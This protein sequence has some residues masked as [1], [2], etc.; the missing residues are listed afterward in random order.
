MCTAAAPNADR[1]QLL[2]AIMQEGLPHQRCQNHPVIRSDVLNVNLLAHESGDNEERGG[3]SEN[4]RG[5]QDA[6]RN[7]VNIAIVDKEAHAAWNPGERSTRCPV[8]QGRTAPPIL[9]QPKYARAN[10]NRWDRLERGLQ[11]PEGNAERLSTVNSVG[12]RVACHSE[13]FPT[14]AAES[15]YSI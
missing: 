12:A 2:P 9:L 15:K 13:L 4:Q 5:K 3:Y 1:F 8:E 11:R 10:C 6:T 14:T 7:V